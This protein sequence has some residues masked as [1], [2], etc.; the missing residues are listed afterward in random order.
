MGNKRGTLTKNYVDFEGH[1]DGEFK[2]DFD[3]KF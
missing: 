3:G 2:G 1:F